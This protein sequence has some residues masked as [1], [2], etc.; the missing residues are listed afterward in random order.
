MERANCGWCGEKNG[1]YCRRNTMRCVCVFCLKKFHAKRYGKN[2][3]SCS[4]YCRNKFLSVGHSFKKLCTHCG[5][6][7]KVILGNL[8]RR[9]SMYC[10]RACFLSDRKENPSKRIGADGYVHV[11]NSR[12]HRVLMEKHLGRKLKRLEYVHHKNGNKSD[13]RVENLE[14]LS[15]EEHTRKH[16]LMK[17]GSSTG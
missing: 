11:G 9:A 14:V 13:N 1:K 10:S 15:A 7:F 5:Q 8:V 12:V 2:Q 16:F 6:E 3:K 17:K 4:Q